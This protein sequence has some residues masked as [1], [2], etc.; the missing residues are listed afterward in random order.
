MTEEK[1]IDNPQN[2]NGTKQ[3]VRR[4]IFCSHKW[5]DIDAI[6][7]D[8]MGG[9]HRCIKCKKERYIYWGIHYRIQK[10]LGRIED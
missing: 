6:G 2:A 8:I 4:S 7:V 3:C 10:W 1:K 5:V 9:Y